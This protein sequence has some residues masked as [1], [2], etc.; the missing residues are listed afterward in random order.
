ME[1]TY[2]EKEVERM[3]QEG[4]IRE[5]SP[6]EARRSVRS[7]IYTVPKKGGKRRPVVNL[8][9][10][11]SHLHHQHFKMLTMK[12]VRAAITPN[13]WMAS[14]DL[15][16]CFWGLPVARDHQRFL[17]F[18]F[19]GKT[20]CFQCLPFG[21][22]PSP[23]FITKLYRVVVEHLQQQGH[24]VMIYIDDILILGEDKEACEKALE[25]T[26]KLLAELG[27]IINEEKSSAPSQTIEYLGFTIDSTKMTISAPSRKLDNLRKAIR[28]MLKKKATARSLA[29]ILGKRNSL[30]D[31]MLASRVHTT[32]LHNLKLELARG[33]WDMEAP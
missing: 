22:G 7:S 15:K 17:A 8:R 21:L 18:D 9:W 5:M 12:D 24:Q 27:A 30:Q 33:S 25:A 32:G 3:L 1:L 31:A 4:A 10:I 28:S 23:W 2:L 13:C 11:N 16:D 26:R 20:F 19:L 14:L 6:E 29:S